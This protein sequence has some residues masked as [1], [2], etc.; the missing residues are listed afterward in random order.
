MSSII[1][2]GVDLGTTNSAAGIVRHGKVDIA[3]DKTGKRTVP[4]YIAYPPNAKPPFLVGASAKSKMATRP[5]GVIYDCKRLIGMKYDDEIVERMKKY[6]S[7]DIVDDGNNKPLVSVKQNGEIITKTPE[8]VGACVLEYLKSIVAAYSGNPNLKDV[9]ITVPAYFNQKQRQATKDA[10]T[11]AGLNVLEIISEPVAAAYAYADQNN[12]GAD[13]KEKTILIYDLGGGT[14]DVTIMAVNGNNYREIGLDGDLFLG[15]SD[16]DVIIMEEVIKAYNEE[17]DEPLTSRQKG[18]LRVQ[19]EEAKTSLK[20]TYE[21][22]IEVTDDFPFTLSRQTMEN[23]LRPY[24]QKTIDICDKL[25][26]KCNK[27]INDID[28]IVLVGGST[29]LNI[30]HEMLTKHFNKNLLKT[31]NPDE[32]VA[33]GATK[34]AYSI[35]QG[36]NPTISTN[37]QTEEKPDERP[38]MKP[39]NV[40]ITC[41]SDIGVN[42]GGR[43]KAVIPRGT[44][45]PFKSHVLCTNTESYVTELT[46]DILQGNHRRASHNTKLHTIRIPDIEPRARGKNMI[47]IFLSMDKN[48]TLSA[49]VADYDTGKQIDVPNIQT[50]LSEEELARMQ[51]RRKEERIMNAKYEKFMSKVNAVQEICLRSYEQIPDPEKQKRLSV[52]NKELPKC[53]SIE[54]VEAFEREILSM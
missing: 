26:A 50:N 53:S 14:F 9:V 51:E 25:I 1:S 21:S 39:V 45:L 23:L 46:V 7:F 22:E 5:E 48:G 17:N 40:D 33:Y 15:G 43:M 36:I 10:G 11:I 20:T 24:I 34:Y 27:T 28:D 4:S 42:V 47:L 37:I 12:I 2:F 8:E 29:R 18:K 54:E 38:V 35:T 44:T 3:A 32:C 16:F 30:V 31:I 13:G 19:C 52:I 41:P 49:S 6:A